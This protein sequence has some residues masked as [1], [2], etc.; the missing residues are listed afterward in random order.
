MIFFRARGSSGFVFPLAQSV[1]LN[2]SV[3]ACLPPGIPDG[4]GLSLPYYAELFF[5]FLFVVVSRFWLLLE[6]LGIFSAYFFSTSLKYCIYSSSELIDPLSSPN[7]RASG[8]VHN[9]TLPHPAAARWHCNPRGFLAVCPPGHPAVPPMPVVW[10][11]GCVFGTRRSF[12]S[13]APSLTRG[14]LALPSLGACLATETPLLESCLRGGELS[15]SHCSRPSGEA[16]PLWRLLLL[17]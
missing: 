8:H 3:G 9:R 7:S 16:P 13:C 15:G 5:L 17:L 14:P 2:C 11:Q 6:R 10:Y 1:C 4:V 12:P